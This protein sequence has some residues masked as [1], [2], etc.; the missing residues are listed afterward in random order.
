MECCCDG[1]DPS[2]LGSTLGEISEG[3]ARAALHQFLTHPSILKVNTSDLPLPASNASVHRLLQNIHQRL[4]AERA[5][6]G[7][8][9]RTTDNEGNDEA[10]KVMIRHP[11]FLA[12]AR[13]FA[14]LRGF[15]W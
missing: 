5:S 9:L 6:Q 3:Q 1:E 7:D 11:F 10:M 4:E 15:I 13:F 8:E 14:T 12:F 2:T